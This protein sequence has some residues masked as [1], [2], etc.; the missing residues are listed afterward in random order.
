MASYWAMPEWDAVVNAVGVF[1]AALDKDLERGESFVTEVL[2][3]TVTV[4]AGGE[5]G[6]MYGLYTNDTITSHVRGLLHRGLAEVER[7]EGP[8]E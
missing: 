1:N 8:P 4:D 3:Q 7:W 6:A 2:V 5:E